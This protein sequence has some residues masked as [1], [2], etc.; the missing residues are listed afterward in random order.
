MIRDDSQKANVAVLKP[1]ITSIVRMI[2]IVSPANIREK[3]KVP[4]NVYQKLITI[5]GSF[6]TSSKN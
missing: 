1:I 5:H 2:A 4:V 3:K 6:L